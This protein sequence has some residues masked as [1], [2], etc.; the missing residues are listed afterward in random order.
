MH[1]TLHPIDAALVIAAGWGELHP[2]AGCFIHGRRLLPGGFVMIYAPR[3]DQDVDTIIEIVKAGA[4]WVGGV[5]LAVMRQRGY[6]KCV[7]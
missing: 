3:T 7:Q 5:D 4:W 6:L 1:M 2:L